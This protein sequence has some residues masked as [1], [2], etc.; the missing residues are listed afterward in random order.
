[1]DT[2]LPDVESFL[3][4]NP[5]ISATAFGLRATND[6]HLVRQMRNGR[7][8]WPETIE[9]VRA[10]MANHSQSDGVAMCGACE[11]P[12]DRPECDACTRTDCGIRQKEAA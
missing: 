1:M 6:R 5:R 7:R 10:F 2:I 3:K 9:R 4:A 12:A 11:L 8:L